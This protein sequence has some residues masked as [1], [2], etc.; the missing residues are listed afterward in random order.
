MNPLEE[1]LLTPTEAGEPDAAAEVEARYVRSIKVLDQYLQEQSIT[2]CSIGCCSTLK[3]I[4]LLP[5]L[6]SVSPRLFGSVNLMRTDKDHITPSNDLVL[7]A[8]NAV[9]ELFQLHGMDGCFRFTASFNCKPGN[10]FFPVAYHDGSQKMTVS[11]ALECGDLLFM[12]FH[13][14]DSASEGSIN[15]E[16]VMRQALSPLQQIVQSACAELDNVVYGGI[17]ASINPGLSLPDSVGF[18]LESL[19]FKAPDRLPPL[20]Q[21]GDWGTLATVSAV[22]RAIKN[23]AVEKPGRDYI[24]LCGY[25][26]L[27]LPVMEDLILAERAAQVPPR[28]SLRDLLTYSAVCGVGLDTVPI[29]GDTST[30]KIAG[31]YHNLRLP[32]RLSTTR[33]ISLYIPSLIPFNQTTNKQGCLWRLHQW[34]SV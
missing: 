27:M 33:I 26:G 34:H 21:F 1:W 17:D 11:L 20:P 8:A 13:G 10:P 16:E 24:Q 29:P 14:A 23:L 4:R 18:G 15:L 6:L 19:L 25:S 28:Y 30:E 3:M 12:A 31:K 9:N 2:F 7:G 32:N 5:K 22:T